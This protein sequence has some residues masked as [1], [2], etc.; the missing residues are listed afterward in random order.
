MIFLVPSFILLPRA[1]GV[2]GIWL[3]LAL[4]EVATTVCIAVFYLWRQRETI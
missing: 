2:A 4:S 3:A 1:L